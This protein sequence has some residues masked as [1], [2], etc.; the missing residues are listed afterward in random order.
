MG[1][2]A[3]TTRSTGIWHRDDA[4]PAV[5][6]RVAVDFSPPVGKILPLSEPDDALSTSSPKTEYFAGVAEWQ[7]QRIQNWTAAAYG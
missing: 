7:T 2:C 4:I 3:R 5:P 6:G 1:G